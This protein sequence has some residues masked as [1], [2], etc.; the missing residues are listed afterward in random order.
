MDGIMKK[1][2]YVFPGQGS[3]Y[4]GM[5]K[6][7]FEEYEEVRELFNKACDILGYNISY[8]CFN[9][10]LSKLNDTVYTQIAVLLTSMGFLKILEKEKRDFLPEAVAGHSLGEYTALYAAK[11]V[12]EE[13]IIELVNYRAKYMQE[14]AERYPGG[15]VAILGLKINEVE[16]ICREINNEYG[17]ESEILQIANLNCPLQV[18]ISGTNK[19]LN[20]AIKRAKEKKAKKLVPL[21]VSGA[22]HSKAMEKA[23][24]KLNYLLH[25]IEF[26]P[27]K[28]PLVANFTGDYVK[29]LDLIRDYLKNQIKSPVLWEKSI[30]N[31]IKNGIDTFVEIGPGRVISGLINRIDSKVTTINVNNLETLR[32][33]IEVEI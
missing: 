10:P 18:I 11:V 20:L 22:F 33:F 19:M 24:D 6:D 12:D 32:N 31:M 4:V 15:M 21:A 23:S 27:F 30:R 3:Q 7:I 25:N 14:E 5:G 29:E 2:A 8:I 9:G 13:S 16:K 17:E 28:I 26:K 1:I